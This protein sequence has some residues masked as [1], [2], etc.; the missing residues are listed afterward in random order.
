MLVTVR[1]GPLVPVDIA[2]MSLSA[3]HQ[4]PH[5]REPARTA[6]RRFPAF[7]T[8]TGLLVPEPHLPAGRAEQPSGETHEG[9]A[10]LVP[11]LDGWQSELLHTELLSQT[12]ERNDPACGPRPLACIAGH[13][14]FPEVVVDRSHP[15]WDQSLRG[16]D[17]AFRLWIFALGTEWAL[18]VDGS[19]TVH[20]LPAPAMTVGLYEKAPVWFVRVVVQGGFAGLVSFLLPRFLQSFEVFACRRR[21]GRV[22][23]LGPFKE[24]LLCLDVPRR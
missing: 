4:E 8:L 1:V 16:P 10:P 3:D 22:G 5:R 21:F 7:R 9:K 19:H 23:Q 6:A 12:V 18:R 13:E 24:R 2:E 14:R 17:S 11:C 20:G 15:E